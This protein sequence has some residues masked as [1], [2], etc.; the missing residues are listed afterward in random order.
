MKFIPPKYIQNN[1]KRALKYLDEG[2]DAM[3]RVGRLRARQL[4]KGE[5]VGK[6]TLEKMHRFRRHQTNASYTGH[7]RDDN[8]A[9]AWLGW[10]A[11]LKRGKGV[12]DAFDWAKRQLRKIEGE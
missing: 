6:V 1:A 10:G 2:S 8:G 12:P 9:V 7:P 3:L 5:P 11:S 4:A